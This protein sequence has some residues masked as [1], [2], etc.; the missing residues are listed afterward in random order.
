MAR[1]RQRMDWSLLIPFFVIS[2]IGLLTLAGIDQTLFYFKRQLVWHVIG[3]A[4]FL[5]MLKFVDRKKIKEWAPVF[6][7]IMLF[8]LLVVLFAGKSSKGAQRWLAIGPFRFQPSEFGK[9]S[10]AL[11]VA[12][13]M[14]WITDKGRLPLGFSEVFL[15]MLVAIPMFGLVLIQPDLGTSFIFIL[16]ALSAVFIAGV[17]KRVLVFGIIASV[18]VGYVGWTHVL[19]GYQ[20]NRIKAFLNP[21]KY[22]TT[23]GYHVIQSRI[24]IGSGRIFGKGYMKATQARLGF[25][26]EKHTDF[27]FASFAESWGFLGT[28]I[29]VMLY[30]FFFSRVVELAKRAK[31]L[32]EFYSIVELGSIFFWHTFINLGMTMGVLPV[33]GVPLPLMSYGGSATLAAYINVACM[34]ILARGDV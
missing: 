14:E 5:L 9:I 22:S 25:M 4:C 18:V 12:Q 21:K 32:F 24:A 15:V 26:P 30:C 20:K 11:V 6:Y 33:V 17:R 3:I 8:I 1:K 2:L 7:G 13:I 27:I 19:K 31:G 10:F 16:M 29:L 28:S 23:I 34:L